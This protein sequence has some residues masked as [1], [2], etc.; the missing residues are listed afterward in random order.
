LIVAALVL[1]SC[2]TRTTPTSNTT[3]TTIH[4]TTSAP[5]PTQTTNN[6]TPATKQTT[7][8]STSGTS[9]KWWDS[10]GVPQ[11]GGELVLRCNTDINNFDTYVSTL[12]SI[13]YHCCPR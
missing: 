4:N 13:I 10:L 12:N 8:S 5:A 2:T 1:A 9:G 6:T 7:T 11:Y 3:V